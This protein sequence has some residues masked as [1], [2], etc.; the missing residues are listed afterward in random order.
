MKKTTS[1]VI[2]LLLILWSVPQSVSAVE[3]LIPVG[4][5]IGLELAD[6]TVCVAAFDEELGT[7]AR[8]AGLQVGDRLVKLDGQPV[9][10]AADVRKALNAADGAVQLR[11]LRDG[12]NKNLTLT[13]VITAQGPKLGVYLKE[14]ITGVGTVTYYDPDTGNYGALG[15]G[16]NTADGALLQ[17]RRGQAYR[18]QILSVRKGRCGAPG[19]LMGALKSEYPLGTISK[20]T[21]CGVFGNAPRRWN[22]EALELCS[23]DQVHTGDAV[24]R[25]TVSG[26]SVQEY[27]VQIVK[28]YPLGKDSGRN[29]LLKITDP[30][31]LNAT[32]GI[33]Q[34]MSG[35]PII[36]DGKLVGAVTHVLVN[37]PTTGYGIFIENM[38]D[39]AA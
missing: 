21:P 10:S 32:G 36:Q 22:G 33:V 25:S 12:K 3:R 8:K 13:P 20:N 4:E 16:V 2:A 14:G 27:S 5:V 39:A 7:A 17:L 26:D 15:H 28:V 18:A 23:A 9:R 19:Q 34:G 35:S 1:A 6:D 30:A 31:L 29:M 38:L 24:I 37:D 11:I